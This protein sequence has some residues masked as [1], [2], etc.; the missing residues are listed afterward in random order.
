MLYAHDK[1][2]SCLRILL[3]KSISFNI[4]LSKIFMMLTFYCLH[5]FYNVENSY[6]ALNGDRSFVFPAKIP[7]YTSTL[8]AGPFLYPKISHIFSM[9]YEVRRWMQDSCT[10]TVNRLLL[11][12]NHFAASNFAV[13]SLNPRPCRG[14]CNPP[15]VFLEPVRRLLGDE[16]AGA[17]RCA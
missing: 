5:I 7:D 8:A 11:V 17:N 10:L 16:R 1:F 6:G 4:L 9:E 3:F 12:A 14:G 15:W 2:I 13:S